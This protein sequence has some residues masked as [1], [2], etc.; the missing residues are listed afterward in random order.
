M[1]HKLLLRSIFLHLD[2]IRDLDEL[3]KEPIRAILIRI[4]MVYFYLYVFEVSRCIGYIE[5]FFILSRKPHFH[6]FCQR[7]CFFYNAGVLSEEFGGK[8]LRG[9]EAGSQ[10]RFELFKLAI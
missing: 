8:K 3:Y 7:G 10:T 2:F 5:D 9:G 4:E 6:Y 1:H